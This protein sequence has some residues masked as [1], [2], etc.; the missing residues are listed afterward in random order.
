MA[1]FRRRARYNGPVA[2]E[3]SYYSKDRPELLRVWPHPVASVLDVGCGSGALGTRLLEE[4]LARSVTGI[5]VNPDAA[6]LAAERYDRV[7][8]T[9]IEADVE[10]ACELASDTDVVVLADV[11]EHLRDPWC[12]LQRLAAAMQPGAGVIVSLPNVASFEVVVP[13]L[14]GRFTYRRDG[15]LDRTHLRFFTRRSARE[16]IEGSG[17]VID[18]TARTYPIRGTVRGFHPAALLGS[19]GARQFIFVCRRP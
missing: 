5:E 2:P 4:G 17:L 15:I 12:V 19:R 7:L 8:V 11:L 14:L 18:R 16:L 9:D 6:T 1:G 13:L 3:P 10:A